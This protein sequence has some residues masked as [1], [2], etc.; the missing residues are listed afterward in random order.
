MVSIAVGQQ[1]CTQLTKSVPPCVDVGWPVRLEQPSSHCLP[2]P[3][4]IQ[5]RR[6]MKSSRGATRCRGGYRIYER[7]GGGGGGGTIY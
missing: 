1:L 4:V 2:S 5:G 7:G 3:V 6:K